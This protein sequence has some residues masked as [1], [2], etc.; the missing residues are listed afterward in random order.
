M[1]RGLAESFVVS[2]PSGVTIKTRLR[3]TP[4]EE[5]ALREVGT[6][7]GSLYRA[8]LVR[9]LGE[10]KRDAA[11]RAA[12]RRERKRG[13]TS[14]SSSRWAGSITRATQDQYDLAAGAL[15]AERAMLAARSYWSWVARVI[16]PAHRDAD[17]EVRP[18]LRSRREAALP[19]ASSF[20]SP[21]RLTRSARY[22]S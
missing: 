16:E 8:D 4:A 1:L 5:Q 20:P 3:P 22:L 12:S 2:P 13:L 19:A 6:F 17:A 14:A 11:G 9:R 10:G 15:A 18:R 7:L 21:K